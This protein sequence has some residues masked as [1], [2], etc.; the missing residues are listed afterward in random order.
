MEQNT[1]FNAPESNQTSGNG[2]NQKKADAFI[3]N[4][5]I[6]DANGNEHAY[7]N[8]YMPLSIDKNQLERSLIEVARQRAESDEEP[9]EITI[10]ARVNLAKVDDGT[11]L[12]F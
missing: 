3:G 8:T 2:K 7:S 6:L 1:Q 12:S 9:L 5:R 4:V 10:K 11:T